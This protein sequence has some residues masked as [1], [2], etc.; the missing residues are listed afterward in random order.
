MTSGDDY[1]SQNGSR[2]LVQSIMS[3]LKNQKYMRM[4]E[5]E[6]TQSELDA[7]LRRDHFEKVKKIIT[8]KDKLG[9]KFGPNQSYRKNII[10]PIAE[11]WWSAHKVKSF[12]NKVYLDRLKQNLKMGDNAYIKNAMLLNALGENK[13]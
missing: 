9:E 10:R 13:E 7:A 4:N 3:T 6:K 8:Q 5:K 11:S 1:Q 2:D 12:S